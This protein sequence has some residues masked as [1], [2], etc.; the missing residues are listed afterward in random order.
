MLEV[1]TV[2][3]LLCLTLAL[4]LG[5]C[6][7]QQ[8]PSTPTSGLQTLQAPPAASAGEVQYRI[9]VTD[10]AGNPI[11]GVMLN[12]CDATS[13][14]VLTTDGAGKAAFSGA[15]YAYKVQALLTP[16]E[17]QNNAEFVLDA[18]GGEFALILKGK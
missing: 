10:E 17:Y 9:T 7:S 11:A 15:P 4:G 5:G 8:G 14:R 1:K 13:C 12:V 3:M 6:A 18:A 16:E 2:L